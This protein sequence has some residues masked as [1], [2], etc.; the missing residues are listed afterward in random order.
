MRQEQTSQFDIVRYWLKSRLLGM[1]SVQSCVLTAGNSL[2]VHT[3]TGVI[4]NV[5]LLHEPGRIRN[6]KRVLQEATTLGIGS[7]F[8]L[9]ADLLPQPNTRFEPA[10]WLLALHTL[11]HERLYAYDIDDKGPK[12]TQIHLEQIGSSAAYIARYG[13]DV[14]FEKLRILKV[15]VKPK[16]MKG[17]WHIADFGLNAFWRDP[18]RAHRTEYRRPDNREFR[19]QSWSQ[20]SWEPGQAQTHDIPKPPPPPMHH[21]LQQSYTLLEVQRDATRDEVKAAF[22]KL[23]IAVHPDTSPLPKAEAESKFRALSEAYEYIKEQN[24]W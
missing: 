3:W 17:D 24:K 15:S 16:I 22:R 20:T 14:N 23:A 21:R 18:Y 12:L 8:I 7:L 10:D 13:P 5:Y 2:V 19:W 1:T 9:D 4:V 6:I 11:M